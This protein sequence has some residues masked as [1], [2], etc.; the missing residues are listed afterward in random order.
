L[1][2]QHISVQLTESQQKRLQI[3]A[4]ESHVAAKK[5][6]TTMLLLLV[7]SLVTVNVVN[8][9]FVQNDWFVMSMAFVSGVLV[10]KNTVTQGREL[11]TD[12]RTKIQEILNNK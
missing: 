5:I 1:E 12:I 8:Q 7:A 11:R 2:S 10:M 6:N 9:L 4:S 3:L